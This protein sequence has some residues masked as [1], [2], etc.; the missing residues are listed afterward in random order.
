MP[1]D[2]IFTQCCE[3]LTLNILP[4][5]YHLLLIIWYQVKLTEFVYLTSMF[6]TLEMAI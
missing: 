4:N 3:N 2:S 5:C 1:E 6:S